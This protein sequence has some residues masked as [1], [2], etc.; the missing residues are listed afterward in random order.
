MDA[1]QLNQMI[2][3]V[4]AADSKW[5][6][7]GRQEQPDVKTELA[8]L[9]SSKCEI[10]CIYLDSGNSLINTQS[11]ILGYVYQNQ[12]PDNTEELGAVTAVSFD[13][14]GN[15]VMFHRLDRIW[16]P[17]TFNTS[18]VYQELY[19]GPISGDTV[20][21]LEAES[22]KVLYKWGKNL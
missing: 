8:K 3:G 18:N 20:L 21:G 17:S 16:G 5:P 10:F 12:W 6:H 11:R 1:E 4:G 2:K 14:A 19:R 15:V 13:K 7:P 9:N 22:G